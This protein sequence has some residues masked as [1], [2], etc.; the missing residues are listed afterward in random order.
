[1]LTKQ[2][3]DCTGD[4]SHCGKSCRYGGMELELDNVVADDVSVGLVGLGGDVAIC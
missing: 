3:R 1:M 4:K 2:E